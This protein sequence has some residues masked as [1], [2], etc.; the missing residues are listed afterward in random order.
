MLDVPRFQR[1]DTRPY[2]FSRIPTKAP[3]VFQVRH[4]GDTNAALVDYWFKREKPG[5]VASDFA[6]MRASFDEQLQEMARF[7]IVGWEGVTEDGVPLE[8]TQENALRALR[9]LA[10][11]GWEREVE[12]FVRWAQFLS[13]FR[14]PIADPA[15]LGKE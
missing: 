2:T 14:E 15:D 1:H 6:T 9:E 5:T 8:C 13:N 11:V 7:C 4:Y 10:A 3:M 12:A